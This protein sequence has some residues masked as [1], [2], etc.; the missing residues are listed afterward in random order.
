MSKTQQRRFTHA[1]ASRSS[2]PLLLGIAG[3]S[4][5]G[6]TFS[7]LRLGTGIVRA[8]G[9]DPAESLFVIDTEAKRSS[10]YAPDPGSPPGPGQFAFQRIDFLPPFAPLDYLAAIEHCI[11]HG[12]RCIIIDSMSHEHEGEGG[13]LD[14]HEAELDRM[15]GDDWKKRDRCTARAWIKPKRDRR[16]LVQSI[17]Q[18]GCT[19]IFCFRAQ[20]KLDWK[21]KDERGQPRDMGWQPIAAAPLVYEMTARALL[22]P[23]S[24]GVPIWDPEREDERQLVKLPEQFREILRGKQLTEELGEAMAR[25]AAGASEPVAHDFAPD[26]DACATTGELAELG[27]RIKGAGLPRAE[28]QRIRRVYKARHAVLSATEDDADA[29][30]MREPGED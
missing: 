22:P 5:S 7:A 8:Y 4:G 11:A 15:A 17:V 29:P 27:E 26:I 23:G 21:R 6:K 3:P 25:W 20:E 9:A 14:M 18:L 16:R 28:A 1:P 2:V 30:R 24:N 19:C 12:A 13:V 10:H